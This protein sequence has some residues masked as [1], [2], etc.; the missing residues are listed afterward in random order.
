MSALKD[1]LKNK[2]TVYLCRYNDISYKDA[3]ADYG[4]NLVIIAFS[5]QTYHN[6]LLLITVLALTFLKLAAEIT[7]SKSHDKISLMGNIIALENIIWLLCITMLVGKVSLF[8]TIPIFGTI[9]TA[10]IRYIH[11]K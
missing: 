9:A 11:K 5:Y 1:K 10:N 4:V 2:L 8:V 3:F 6:N 7:Y